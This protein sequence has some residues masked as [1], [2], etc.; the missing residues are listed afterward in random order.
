M[1]IGP[2]ISV[3]LVLLLAACEASAPSSMYD[4]PT[5]TQAVQASSDAVDTPEWMRQRSYRDGGPVPPMEANR[6]VNEQPCTEGIVL[7]AGNLKCK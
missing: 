5:P 4:R 6:T 2:V 3:A 7:A 1:S